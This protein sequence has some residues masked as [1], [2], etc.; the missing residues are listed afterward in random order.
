VTRDVAPR[1]TLHARPRCR[2]CGKSTVGDPV[3]RDCGHLAVLD[4]AYMEEAAQALTF[5]PGVDEAG[6]D[7]A[8]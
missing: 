5:S 1:S 4:D 3:C 7:E 8:A 6:D 2:Y